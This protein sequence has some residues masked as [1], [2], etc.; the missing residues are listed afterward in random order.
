MQNMLLITSILSLRL[1][2]R[3][4]APLSSSINMSTSAAVYDWDRGQESS[5]G[6][7]ECWL[8]MFIILYL[9]K[10]LYWIAMECNDTSYRPLFTYW[11][12]FYHS[13]FTVNW[14]QIN[15]QLVH[16]RH[17][18]SNIFIFIGTCINFTLLPS[19]HWCNNKL[20]KIS[21][22]QPDCAW[23]NNWHQLSTMWI[24]WQQLAS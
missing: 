3:Q 24:K 16:R 20:K 10:P 8:C 9:C 18:D 11:W 12:F 1:T 2:A 19:D 22:M 13:F 17:A 15:I 14:R 21:T 5:E 6:G 7:R 23:V 4:R